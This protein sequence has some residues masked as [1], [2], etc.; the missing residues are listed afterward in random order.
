MK[1][2]PLVSEH[3]WDIKHDPWGTGLLVAG[4]IADVLYVEHGEIPESA[5][6]RPPM[7]G[8]FTRAD[9]TYNAVSGEND[10]QADLL[11]MLDN[12]AVTMADLEHAMRVLD[13]YLD[14]VKLAGRDY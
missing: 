13:R 9:L 10:L 11:Q 6:Y 1:L 4:A 5:G 7:M 3:F 12:E 2:R 14:L 8:S